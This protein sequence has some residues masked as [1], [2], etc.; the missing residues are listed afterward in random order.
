[1]NASKSDAGPTRRLAKWQESSDSLA[2]K[3][4]CD[5]LYHRYVD[6]YELES[7]SRG[8]IN[9]DL[10]DVYMDV[11]SGLEVC[12]R[13]EQACPQAV[14]VWSFDFVCHWGLHCTS[15]LRALHRL[16]ERYHEDD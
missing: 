16:L 15:A 9:D 13:G 6:P 1:M 4:D 5:H 2:E 8:A 11:K 10:A 12:S 14:W 7:V 3:L